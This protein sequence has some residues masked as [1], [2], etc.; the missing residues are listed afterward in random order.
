MKTL[1]LS[2]LVLAAFGRASA[3]VR[4]ELV[5]DQKQFLPD[6][7]LPLTVK[8]TN[9]SGQPLSLGAEPD[10]LTFDVESDDQSVVS[11]IGDVPVVEPFDLESSQIGIKHVDLQPYFQMT[12]TGRYKVTA[13]MRIRQ[14][15]LTVNSVPVHLDIVHGAE[16]WSQEFGVAV[17][18]NRPPEIRKFSLIKANFLREQL[19]LYVELS[20]GDGSLIYGVK[21]LGPL[22][23]FSSPEAQ[24]DP[25]THLHVL[26]QTG[27]QSFDYAKIGVDGLVQAREIYDNF[28]SRPHLEVTADGDVLVHGGVRRPKPGEV[29]FVNSTQ[30]QPAPPV[31]NATPVAPT[32]KQ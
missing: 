3:Q 12:R 17:A 24:L 6:E 1:L 20:N 19:R 16:V 2:L 8:I 14:W 9:T 28:N 29:P 7:S 11:K 5:L 15:S 32:L 26:W 30:V 27:A 4:L 18:S 25:L 22:V 10:W 13:T 23:S 31:T 21:S